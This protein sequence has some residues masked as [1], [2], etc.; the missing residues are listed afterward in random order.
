MS[1]LLRCSVLHRFQEKI[2]DPAVREYFTS[3]G[4]DVWD[5]WSFFKLLDLDEGLEDSCTR[6]NCVVRLQ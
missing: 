4:L 5:A 3:I 6:K 1:V 2:N